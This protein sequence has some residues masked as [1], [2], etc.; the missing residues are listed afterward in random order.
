MKKTYILQIFL[1]LFAI[2]YIQISNIYLYPSSH[3]FTI[4]FQIHF[5]INKIGRVSIVTPFKLEDPYI[6]EWLEY[7]LKLGFDHFYL[8]DNNDGDIDDINMIKRLKNSPISRY[9]TFEN[10]RNLKRF[11][12]YFVD[13]NRYWRNLQK[14]DWLFVNLNVDEFL[15][16]PS[17]SKYGHT[18]REY[19]HNA[20]SKKCDIIC[21]NWQTYGN[22]GHHYQSDEKVL[23]RF[24][25]PTLPFNFS[26]SRNYVTK[27]IG[28]GG[29]G[30]RIF[31]H[32]ILF[33]EKK[34]HLSCNGDLNPGKNKSLTYSPSI[35][36]FYYSSAF[37][38]HF[39]T[40]STEEW[41]KYILDILGNILTKLI[42]FTLICRLMSL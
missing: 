26:D 21:F 23:D 14:E 16:F 34:G 19:L 38:K 3:I 1:F 29:L 31:L 13:S 24:P 42:V 18:I 17:T 22:N 25:I 2:F 35:D 30:T 6:E 27:C 10:K 37:L 39:T 4:F 12:D 11:N 33:D 36:S 40:K 7:H 32:D 8:L 9:I 15:T 28:H 5:S 41:F 20:I